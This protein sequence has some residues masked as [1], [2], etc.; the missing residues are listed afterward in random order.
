MHHPARDHRVAIGDHRQWLD[1]TADVLTLDVWP[2]RTIDVV[3]FGTPP[4]WFAQ[5]SHRWVLVRVDDGREYWG[6]LVA[7]LQVTADYDI[8]EM[9][10]GI[11]RP[12]DPHYTFRAVDGPSRP[13]WSSLGGPP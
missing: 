8:K 11:R 1:V 2:D 12:I 9:Q 3:M 6:A 5:A 4:K 13:P 7:P 10:V